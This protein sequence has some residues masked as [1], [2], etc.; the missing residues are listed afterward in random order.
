MRPASAGALRAT[1][2]AG[3]PARADNPAAAGTEAVSAV[4]LK[5]GQS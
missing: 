5:I 4:P 3:K 2:T 1:V